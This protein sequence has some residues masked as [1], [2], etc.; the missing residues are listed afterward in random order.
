MNVSAVFSA[1]ER[2]KLAVLINNFSVFASQV[3]TLSGADFRTRSL[4]NLAA[5]KK[6]HPQLL[7]RLD[8]L[9]RDQNEEIPSRL[10]EDLARMPSDLAQ[11]ISL[12]RRCLLA[13]AFLAHYL[14]QPA[15]EQGEP[16]GKSPSLH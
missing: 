3:I 5:V 6:R 16:I 13:S 14:A 4:R 15:E 10:I 7:G 2:Q 8:D 12:I 9:A 11:A 1:T